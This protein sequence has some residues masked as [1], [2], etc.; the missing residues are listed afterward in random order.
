[1]RKDRLYFFTFLSVAVLFSIIASIAYAYLVKESTHKLLETHL[2]FSQKEAKTYASFL[3]D[4]L[5]STRSKDTLIANIQRS[6]NETENNIGFL[7]IYDWSGKVVAHPDIKKVGLVASPN[8]AFVRHSFVFEQLLKRFAI[9]IITY[10]RTKNGSGAQG[11]NVHCHIGSS[12]KSFLF[13][14]Q[15]K[16]RHW[17]FLRYFTHLSPHVVVNHHI[18]Y[19]KNRLLLECIKYLLYR[20]HVFVIPVR[21][22]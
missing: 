16:N 1:M 21:T 3:G 12:P 2:E 5:L 13:L 15:C 9:C 8:N 14:F 20:F 19:Y 6:L 7:S 22:K 10:H 17:C 18:T 4:Q 11:L